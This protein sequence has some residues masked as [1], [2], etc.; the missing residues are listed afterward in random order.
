M[1]ARKHPTAGKQAAGRKKA[2]KLGFT[3]EVRL[4]AAGNSRKADITVLKPDGTTA[5][6]DRGDLGD[7]RERRRLA[8][9]FADRFGEDPD[10]W[11]QALERAHLDAAKQREAVLK[12]DHDRP[13]NPENHESPDFG[14]RVVGGRVCMARTVSGKEVLVPLCNFT[15]FI[16]EDVC[17]DDGSGETALHFTIEGALSN[18]SPL[19]PVTV[20]AADFSGMTW[21]LTA[22][23]HKAIVTPGQGNKDHLR[24]AIQALSTSALSRTIYAH[25][26]WRRLDPHWAYLHAGGAVT[27]AGVDLGVSVRLDGPLARF[28]LPP[29]PVGDE[30][31]EAVRSSLRLLKLSARLMAPILGVVYRSVLGPADCSLH[32]VGHTGR[33][34]SELLALA[35]QVDRAPVDPGLDARGRQHR[36]RT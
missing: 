15:A 4:P 14:Y 32:L 33:G 20:K 9:K 3:I 10:R 2:K 6:T 36:K 19:S 31:K 21:P 23:G 13:R 30:L 29:P 34:K 5:T 27:A 35:A 12:A 17:I 26:G 25:T 16:T 18:G 22:W 28:E 11:E 1:P 8:R 7:G 24:A